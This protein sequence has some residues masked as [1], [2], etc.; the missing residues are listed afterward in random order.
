[1]PS[2]PSLVSGS[3]SP[4][5]GRIQTCSAP[6]S[7]SATPTCPREVERRFSTIRMRMNSLWKSRYEGWGGLNRSFLISARYVSRLPAYFLTPLLHF[8]AGAYDPQ[9]KCRGACQSMNKRVSRLDD[10]ARA[11]WLYYV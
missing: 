9:Q 5:H 3:A 11:G 8:G 4:F 7:S 10:A 2:K 1:M 6:A